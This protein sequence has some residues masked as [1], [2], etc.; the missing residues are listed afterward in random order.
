MNLKKLLI[1][2]GLTAC[3]AA[4]AA[5]APAAPTA[6]ALDAAEA[7][8]AGGGE[9]AAISPLGRPEALPRRQSA[10]LMLAAYEGDASG[11]A[12]L[13]EGGADV[14]A[15]DTNGWTPLMFALRSGQPA[16]FVAGLL[17][18]YHALAAA[19]AKDGTTAMMIA[20]QYASD[21]AVVEALYAADADAVQPRRR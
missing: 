2:I 17:T 18:Q 7:A 12:R 19:E 14:N 13:V 1:L 3:C 21:P 4:G 10:A 11:V 15:A 9:A 5:A 8:D 20:C 16:A 6:D